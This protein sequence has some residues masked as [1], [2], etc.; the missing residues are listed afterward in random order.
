MERVSKRETVREMCE[1]QSSLALSFTFLHL[2]L[3]LNCKGRW[4]T[5]DDFTISFVQFSVLQCPLGLGELQACPF[6][7]VVFPPFLLSASSSPPF[8]VPCKMVLARPDERETC[9]N[10]YS[11][12]PFTMFSVGLRVVRLPAGSW[13]GLPRW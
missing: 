11:L 7:D 8:I 3:L 12:R 1:N 9:P 13:H 10:H 5:T 6:P 4:G 2:H